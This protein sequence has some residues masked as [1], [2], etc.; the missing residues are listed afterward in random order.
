MRLIVDTLTH[1][2][3]YLL[4]MEIKVR[5]HFAMSQLEPKDR[6]RAWAHTHTHKR[7]KNDEQPSRTHSQHLNSL[8]RQSNTQHKEIRKVEMKRTNEQ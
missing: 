6:H 8:R 7:Y 5:A 4:S 2:N 3:K 1:T